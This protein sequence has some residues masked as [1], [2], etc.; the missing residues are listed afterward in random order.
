MS[1]AYVKTCTIGSAVRNSRGEEC[2]LSKKCSGQLA[3]PI[4]DRICHRFVYVRH[5]SKSVLTFWTIY[6]CVNWW[7]ITEI[8]EIRF[9]CDMFIVDL[10]SF[11]K[12]MG[13]FFLSKYSCQWLGTCITLSCRSLA[14][15]T[16]ILLC[17][18]IVE[19]VESINCHRFFDKLRWLTWLTQA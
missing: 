13:C 1:T 19:Q 7:Y 6:V 15:S 10:D 3:C 4:R 9:N 18:W 5:L 14:M 17:S 2:G 11:A 12:G 8:S 16:K